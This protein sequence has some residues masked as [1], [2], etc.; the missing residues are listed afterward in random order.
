MCVCVCVYVIFLVQ[1]V[2]HWFLECVFK[3]WSHV[4]VKPWVALTVCAQFCEKKCT[5]LYPRESLP[6]ECPLWVLHGFPQFL[7]LLKASVHRRDD[8]NFTEKGV[9]SIHGV[10]PV[11]HSIVFRSKFINFLVDIKWIHWSH[12]CSCQPQREYVCFDEIKKTKAWNYNP[13]LSTVQ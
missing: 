13:L 12:W 1:F 3:P 8:N 6:N 5:P 2:I 7:V 4:E 11:C 10:Y 9:Q